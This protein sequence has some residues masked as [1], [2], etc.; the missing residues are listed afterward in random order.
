MC[1]IPVQQLAQRIVPRYR[2]E[3]RAGA[4]GLFLLRGVAEH[5]AFAQRAEQPAPGIERALLF[6]G[7]HA[8]L[9]AEKAQL[10]AAA[11]AFLGG[12]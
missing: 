6:I 10:L 1:Q 7:G 4:K 8:V 9:A 12:V 2:I 11:A 3:R 5:A